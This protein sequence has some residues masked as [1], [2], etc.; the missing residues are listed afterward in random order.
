MYYVRILIGK[1][2]LDLPNSQAEL[3]IGAW[4]WME[5]EVRIWK[6]MYII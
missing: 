5:L 2:E 3:E 4:I 6:K 1:T